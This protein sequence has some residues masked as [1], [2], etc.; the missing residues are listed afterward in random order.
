MTG[1]QTC[2][3]PISPVYRE[4]AVVP[5]VVVK[6]PT[7]VDEIELVI[8]SFVGKGRDDTLISVT[9]DRRVVSDCVDIIEVG[10]CLVPISVDREIQQGA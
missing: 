10:C 3:L 5:E 2:A 8:T 7:D 4:D 1:V 6:R 9:D